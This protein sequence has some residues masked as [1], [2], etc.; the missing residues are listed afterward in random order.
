MRQIKNEIKK[1]VYNQH[2]LQSIKE[3]IEK[4]QIQD[5]EQKKQKS[6]EGFM[7]K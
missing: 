3:E 7:P 6:L 2:R 1:S 5:Y 4:P